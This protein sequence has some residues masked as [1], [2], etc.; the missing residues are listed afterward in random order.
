MPE[1]QPSSWDDE[2]SGSGGLPESVPDGTYLEYLSGSG[3]LEIEPDGTSISNS[4]EARGKTAI[5][6]HLVELIDFPRVRVPGEADSQSPGLLP[7]DMQG[8]WADGV[9]R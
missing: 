8:W 1:R 9:I 7:E 6:Q 3:G 4:G 5:W 2:P